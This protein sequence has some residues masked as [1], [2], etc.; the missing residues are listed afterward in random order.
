MNRTVP[1]DP[2][3]SSTCFSAGVRGSASRDADFQHDIEMGAL[4]GETSAAD[5]NITSG[6]NHYNNRASFTAQS[7]S[8]CCGYGRFFTGF[9]PVIR[10]NGLF[11]VIVVCI[12]CGLAMPESSCMRDCQSRPT[13]QQEA[14]P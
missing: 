2:N 14:W 4:L 3:I 8:S 13:R 6:T 1:T 7:G 5:S 9:G 11:I 12:L 10:Q